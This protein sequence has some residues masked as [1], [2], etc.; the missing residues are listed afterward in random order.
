MSVRWTTNWSA[1]LKQGAWP[2]LEVIVPMGLFNVIGSLQNLESAEAAGD[3]YCTRSSLLANVI[4]TLAAAA[5]GRP[6][7]TTLY[8]S[9][10]GWKAMGARSA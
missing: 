7:P 5:F 8:I 4:G 2:Y 6:F 9:H 1:A 10:P 3:R